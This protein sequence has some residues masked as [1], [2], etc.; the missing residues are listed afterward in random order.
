MNNMDL[1]KLKTSWSKIN[2]LP[3]NDIELEKMTSLKNHPVLKKIKIKLLIET[4]TISLFLIVYYS[5]FDGAE[6]PL[7][8]NAFLIVGALAYIINGILSFQAI[9]KPIHGDNLK[10]SINSYFKRIKNISIISLSI[11]VLYTSCLLL[12]FGSTVN[13]S[14]KKKWILIFGIIVLIQAFFWSYRIWKSW[15]EKLKIQ[16]E[17]FK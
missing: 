9:Q 1:Q 16:I 4:I 15:L 13:F 10:K 7:Y 8:A 2:Y 12:F 5:G 11:T 14:G 6:K 3:K 17:N